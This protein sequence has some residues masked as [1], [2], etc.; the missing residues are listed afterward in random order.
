MAVIQFLGL[1]VY[2]MRE[3]ERIHSSCFEKCILK[4]IFS[5][6]ILYAIILV[7]RSNTHFIF[8]W[9]IQVAQTK[10]PRAWT[11]LMQ[12]DRHHCRAEC[13]ANPNKVC[14]LIPG[15]FQNNLNLG[16]SKI[17]QICYEK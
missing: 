3:L 17:I 13:D 16:E 7:I 9:K 6:I 10:Q 12:D 11:W 14:Y 4:I 1:L 8:H 2:K 5:Y 15:H